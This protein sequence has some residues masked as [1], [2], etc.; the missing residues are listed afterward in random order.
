MD[1]RK[2]DALHSE[3]IGKVTTAEEA[4]IIKREKLNA[5][6]ETAT[7]TMAQLEEERNLLELKN[8]AAIVNRAIALQTGV[9]ELMTKI[10]GQ[11]LGPLDSLI[12]AGFFRS[13]I[14]F[15][16]TQERMGVAKNLRMLEVQQQIQQEAGGKVPAKLTKGLLERFNGTPN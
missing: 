7:K 15:F 11:S 12:V 9:Q 2:Y 10:Y 3:N 13:Q 14:T 6:A 4:L 16:E 1:D 5:D 8:S